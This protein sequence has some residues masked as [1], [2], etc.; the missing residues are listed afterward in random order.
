MGR[1][2]SRASR[3]RHPFGAKWPLLLRRDRSRASS[4]TPS[5]PPARARSPSRTWRALR[6]GGAGC[7]AS[8]STSGRR[9]ART[10][11]LRWVWGRSSLLPAS[12]SEAPR[13]PQRSSSA[14]SAAQGPWTARS[15]RSSARPAERKPPPRRASARPSAL[16]T[17]RR[18]PAARPCCPETWETRRRGGFS[19]ATRRA[20]SR[21]LRTWAWGVG[22]RSRP[23]GCSRGRSSWISAAVRA[24]IA[25]S[26]PA[27]SGRT[28]T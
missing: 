18:S 25:S 1:L 11:R 19:W 26:P 17:P 5:G 21:S 7:A 2:P 6:R 8:A 14:P 10:L 24:W 9:A 3:T 13:S 27:R 22:T 20:T 15:R 4:S 28:D 23:P 12:T 16:R